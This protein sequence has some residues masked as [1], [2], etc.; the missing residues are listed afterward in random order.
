MKIKK[1]KTDEKLKSETEKWLAKLEEQ[2]EAKVP[3]KGELENRVVS[4]A[5]DNV[6]AYVR[7]CRHFLEKCDYFNAF[8]A[9]IYAYGIWETLERMGLLVKK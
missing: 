2:L 7:D 6:N 4:N 1:L 5:M 3:A 9:I 8:E